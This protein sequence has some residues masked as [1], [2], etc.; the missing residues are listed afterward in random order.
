MVLGL[1]AIG[2]WMSV[3]G[4]TKILPGKPENEALLSRVLRTILESDIASF[5]DH[6]HYSTFVSY[7]KDYLDI[8]SYMIVS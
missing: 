1:S 8:G 4:R 6:K 3:T 2:D 5:K 7:S